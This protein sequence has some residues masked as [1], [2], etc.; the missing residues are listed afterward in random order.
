[1]NVVALGPHLPPL[2]DL[3]SP[4]EGRFMMVVIIVAMA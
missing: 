2:A 1:M 4:L 3:A